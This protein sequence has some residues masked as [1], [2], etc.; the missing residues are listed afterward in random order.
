MQSE[1]SASL[2]REF[3]RVRGRGSA[4][5]FPLKRLNSPSCRQ[6]MRR[7]R[8]ETRLFRSRYR[9][10]ENRQVS[11]DHK[12]R[13]VDT[14]IV[15]IQMPALLGHSASHAHLTIGGL[16]AIRVHRDCHFC[17]SVVRD[18]FALDAFPEGW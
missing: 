2:P 4:G 13:N 1:S 17:P 18:D 5:P 9:I 11:T 3:S 15:L 7:L 16:M 12:M 10:Q 8:E 6:A 14:L